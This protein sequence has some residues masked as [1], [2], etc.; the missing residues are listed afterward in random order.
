MIAAADVDEFP[1]FVR[2]GV[3]L[4][5]QPYTE[6]PA[7]APLTHLVLRCFPGEDGKTGTSTLYEDD[8]VSAEYAKGAAATTNLSYLRKGTRV[9]IHIAPTEGSYAKQPG[10][11]GYILLLPNTTGAKLVS[12]PGGPT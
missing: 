11:R 2:G 3:P 7:T 12:P 6:R 4:P 10:A 5:E 8:G 1:L 9:S